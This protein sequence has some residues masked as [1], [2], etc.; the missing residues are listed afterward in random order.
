MP[1]LV[2]AP[3]V[4]L[5]IGAVEGGIV[6]LV[7]TIIY[8]DQASMVRIDDG[9]IYEAA[10][11]GTIFG[12]FA[13]ALIG[14]I[15]ALKDVRGRGGLFIGSLIGILLSIYILKDAGPHDDFW[16]ILAILALPSACSMGFLSA[17]LTVSR[18]ELRSSA[19]SDKSHRII[20]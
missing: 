10:I 9:R 5:L 8:V 14:L 18:E 1:R 3:A 13:G 12:S 15:V 17:A 11:Y 7:L 16:R 2:T 4:G 20:S 6:F 19:G